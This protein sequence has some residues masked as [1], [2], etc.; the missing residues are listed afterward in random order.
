MN[1]LFFHGIIKAVFFIL[2]LHS[3][4]YAYNNP[5]IITSSPIT[6]VNQDALYDYT[7]KATDAE[8]DKL[9]WSVTDG[10]ALP[11][12]LTLKSEYWVSTLAGQVGKTGSTDG[13]GSSALFSYPRGIIIDK[14]GIIYVADTDNNKIRKITPDGNVTTFAG[15]GS[16]G[17]TDGIGTAASFIYPQEIAMD[18]DGNIYVADEG[19]NKIRKITPDG[20]VTTFA[21]NGDAGYIDGNLSD[22]SF[23]A[24]TGI[25]IDSIGNIY[26]ADKHNNVIRKI[27][28][29]GIVTTFATGFS[30]PYGVKVD[31]D[32]NI[33]VVDLKHHQI[34]KLNLR[35]QVVTI[36]GN[37]WYGYV[38]GIASYAEF[39]YPSDIAIDNAGNMYVTDT[40]N[41]LIR[42]IIN[43]SYLTGTPR[44]ADVG[45]YV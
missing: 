40:S 32:D 9:T 19:N 21:G 1:K 33:Y 11:S 25:T 39:I 6:S 24:P 22:A 41:Q 12:W 17:S 31:K 3:T 5:P 10:T 8:N 38:D 42:K 37:G 2:L 30:Y 4:S 44:N 43:K 45:T 28:V 29:D 13:I 26:V 36:I 34:K 20:N 14:N 23:N 35:G 15:S 7:L 27:S 16:Y 18:T